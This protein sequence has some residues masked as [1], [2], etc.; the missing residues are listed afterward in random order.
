[1]GWPGCCDFVHVQYSIVWIWDGDTPGAGPCGKWNRL[2]EGVSE[3]IWN[4]LYVERTANASLY[5]DF[6]GEG[7]G[8]VRYAEKYIQ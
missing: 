5:G 1:M 2:G 4:G 3:G 7:L 8:I 6:Q